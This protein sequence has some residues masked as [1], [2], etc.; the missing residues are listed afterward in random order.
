M[1][2]TLFIYLNDMFSAYISH[3]IYLKN[4]IIYFFNPFIINYLTKKR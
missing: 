3:I 4:D 2:D 1:S